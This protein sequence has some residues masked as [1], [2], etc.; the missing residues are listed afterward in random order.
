MSKAKTVFPGYRYGPKGECELFQSEDDVPKGW[1]RNT[2]EGLAKLELKDEDTDDLDG[3]DK[4]AL[5][6]TAI[7]EGIDIEAIKGSG[8]GGNVL[9]KD[10]RAAIEVKR[11]EV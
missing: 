4:E 10:L 7:A 9:V 6:A 11:G 5:E 3:L 1:H 2:P 8:K